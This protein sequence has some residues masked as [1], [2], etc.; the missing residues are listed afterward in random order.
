MFRL[1][2]IHPGP[3][4][5]LSAAASLA[6]IPRPEAAAMLR[7]LV[8][9]H[10]VAE[11]VHARYTFH[12]LLRAY[13]ADL[14]GR[15]DS[16]QERRAAAH[17]VLDHYLYSALSAWARF[18]PYRSAPRDVAPQPGVVAVDVADKNQARA[19]FDAEAPVLFALVGYA[20]ASGFDEHAWLIPWA[21]SAYLNPC[22]RWQ[23]WVA[24]ERVAVAAAKRLNDP[25]AQAHSHF[26]LGRALSIIGDSDAAEPNARQA[27]ALFRELEDRGHE[28]M[29]LNTL[30]AMMERQG[31]YAEALELAQDG[32]RMVKAVGHWWLQGALENSV[33]WLHAHLGHY[34][35]ALAHCQRAVGLHRE[36]GTQGGVACTLDSI[37]HIYLRLGDTVQARAYY[38]QALAMNRENGDPFGEGLALTGLGDTHAAAGDAVAARAAWL[39]AKAILHRLA[40]PM[41]DDVRAKLATLDFQVE[42]DRMPSTATHGR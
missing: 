37:G 13:A 39:E 34:D 19:W 1:L 15:L 41:A 25:R 11:T 8:R 10:M 36:A 28:A 6:G 27:L 18:S 17:R 4:I 22:G 2:G 30:S 23:D 29:A 20:D 16:D 35:Q 40:H 26:Q 3:D 31:R 12:E 14:A 33:G 7:E 5:S 21:M 9:T 32:L 38:E 24:I 42:P